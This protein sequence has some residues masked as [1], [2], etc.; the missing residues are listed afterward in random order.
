MRKV[1]THGEFFKV[2]E[3]LKKSID[4]VQN[5]TLDEV[6][7]ECFTDTGIRPSTRAVREAAQA[8]GHKLG[9]GRGK[10]KA[11]NRA[12]EIAAAVLEMAANFEA[13]L[14]E[15]LLSPETVQTMNEIRSRKALKK[16]AQ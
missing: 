8:T 15:R 7:A 12:A 14:N 5:K 16:E 6:S 1:L 11:T 3:W 10:V 2:C 4:Q 13:G 9:P